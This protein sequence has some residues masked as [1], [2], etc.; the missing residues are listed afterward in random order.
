[1]K[2]GHLLGVD[3]GA[4]NLK[5]VELKEKKSA[6]VLKNIA[7]KQMPANTIVDGMVLD[8]NAAAGV[9]Q[10]CLAIMKKPVKDCA[11]GMRGRDVVVKKLNVPWN[12]KGSFQ[13]SFVWG[14]EQYI[15]IKGSRATFDAQ[16][17][18]FDKEKGIA[19]CVAA[20]AYKDKV[21]DC[22]AMAELAG[23][24]PVVVDIEALAL[25]NTVNWLKGR[26][27]H[28]NAI[29]DIGHDS[30]N[31]IFYENGYVDMVKSIPRGIKNLIED[32]A[33]DMD[34]DFDKA[35]ASVRNKEFMG[36]DPDAQAC[37]MSFGSG[38]GAELETAM[39]IY[40]SERRKEP[41]D[42][43]VCGAGAY[44][45]GILEQAEIAMKL[46]MSRINPF[47]GIEVPEQFKHVVEQAGPAAF[48]VAAG[49]AMRKA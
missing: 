8:H 42:F 15:G 28:V 24:K 39:E 37:S 18:H 14:A 22:I 13:E 23:L 47:E 26:K 49:L 43:F 20:A 4:A 21:A 3:A 29:V 16:L 38:L 34:G 1:M 6:F 7:V 31:V 40:M 33:Q 5:M 48:A 10:N 17:L 35:G 2:F 36:S 27:E 25:V 41:V 32:L 12:G 30:T 44:I 19:E 46:S 9:I 45:P 11:L